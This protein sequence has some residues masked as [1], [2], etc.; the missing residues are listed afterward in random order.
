MKSFIQLISI[1]M[2][3]LTLCACS[4]E[5]VSKSNTVSVE[6]LSEKENAILSTTS[7]KSFVF[8]FNI[9]NEKKE[10]RVWIEK[11]E[12]GE[13][14]EDKISDLTSMV[15]KTGYIIFTTSKK[16]ESQK[17]H[18]FNIGISS[19]DTFSSLSNFDTDSDKLEKMS[20]TWSSF[21]DEITEVNGEVVLASICYSSTGDM[22]S[23]TKDFYKDVE[24]HM[25]ELEECDVVYLLKTEFIN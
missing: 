14:V 25:N 16:E 1:A 9:E 10:V 5:A 20:S 2:L 12:F 6:K 4:N 17:H 23:L 18:T 11:Y 3:V 21:P 7:D 13:L 19:N 24:A 8:D 15:E 22:T